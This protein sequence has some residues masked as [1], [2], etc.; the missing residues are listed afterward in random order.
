MRVLLFFIFF[1]LSVSTSLLRGQDR[2]FIVNGKYENTPFDLFIED[3]ERQ[4]PVEFLYHPQMADS[5]YI[6]AVFHNESLRQALN[7]VFTGTRLRYFMNRDNKVILTEDYQVVSEL[8]FGFFDRSYEIQGVADVVTA[9]F[10]GEEE[11]KTKLQN[12]LEN[13]VIEIGNTSAVI[14]G[15]YANLAGHIRD[16]ATGEPLIG[17]LIYIE[18]PRIGVATDQFGYFSLTIPKGRQELLMQC[19]GYKNTKRQIILFGNG[20]LEIDMTEDVIPLKEVIIESEKDVNI[21]GMQMGF[22]KLDVQSMKK[23]P[24]V[25]GE[26]D[27]LKIAL[28]LPGVQSVGEGANGINVRGGTADQNLMLINDAPIYNPTHLFGF[29]SSFNPDVIKSVELHKGGIPAQ[30][31]GRISSVF[32][33]QAKEGNNKKFVGSGGISPVTARLTFEGPIIKNKASYIIGGRTTYS[34]WILKQL[35]DPSVKNSS[36]SFYDLYGKMSYDVNDKNTIYA[37]G[38][39]S[40]D[41]F[42]FN[43]DTTYGY[44]NENVSLQWKHIFNNKLYGVFS[45][46]YSG[47]G[48]HIFSKKN[49]VNAFDMQYRIKNHI[50]KIDFSYFPNSSHKIDFGISS[51]RYNLEPGTFTPNGANSLID[52]ILLE[53]EQGREHAIYLGDKYDMNHRLSLYLGLRYSLYQYIGPKTIRQYASNG[54]ITEG[55]KTGEKIYNDNE[56]I[57]TYHGPELRF[58]ARYSIGDES[59]VKLSYNKMRQYI[60][61][62]SNTTSISPTDI[63]KLSDPYFKPQIGDQVSLGYYRN[64]KN[65]TI[66]GSVEGYYKSIDNLLDFKS[67][68]QLILNDHLETDIVG[69]VG[70]SYGVE[71][72]L[73]KK[74]GKLNGWVSYTYSRALIQVDGK[75]PGESVNNG[76]FYPASF[77]KPHAFNLLSNW[78]FSRRL[79]VSGNLAYSTGRPVTYPVAKYVYRGTERVHYSERNQFRIPDY[80][81]L[82]LSINIEGNHKVKKLNHSSWTLAVYNITGRNNVYS[83]YF[84][85]QDGKVKGYQLSIFAEAIPTITYNFRF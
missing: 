78:K 27:V 3:I 16:A 46:V 31:G 64:F 49:E 4:V 57:E 56:V 47:Y 5:F 74:T 28:T 76:E 38:Y 70:K 41:K 11:E 43:S 2:S 50:G 69:G 84:V 6:N 54:P 36:A 17:A 72:L 73:K 9:D 39:Y 59:S 40:N 25:L 24:P 35:P 13:T 81:R 19:I 79:S 29:F 15:Q 60:H 34:N 7:R 55:T 75:F 68:A 65:N 61:M 82:D 23:V 52:E 85:S 83:I 71:M 21:A 53:K 12:T 42:S 58:S 66:E 45:G 30:Y 20:K 37:A 22:D 80:F 48:Y 18:N 33:V 77:D 14:D 1:A 63:W 10:P 51:T 44:T 26:V 67:G 32:E 8:P 62:L